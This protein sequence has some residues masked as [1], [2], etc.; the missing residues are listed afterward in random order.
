MLSPLAKI[1]HFIFSKTNQVIIKQGLQWC[2]ISNSRSKSTLL[3]VFFSFILFLIQSTSLMPP[4]RQQISMSVAGEKNTMLLKHCEYMSWQHEWT[5]RNMIFSSYLQCLDHASRWINW[6]N[7]CADL[8]GIFLFFF[9]C[10]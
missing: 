4:V 3:M 9:F 5:F 1:N 10:L 8:L 2:R 6:R 7:I